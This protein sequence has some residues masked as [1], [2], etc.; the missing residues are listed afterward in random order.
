M[1]ARRPATLSREAW[2]QSTF[3]QRVQAMLLALEMALEEATRFEL[4]TDVLAGER[5]AA[6]AAMREWAEEVE[7]RDGLHGAPRP[8]R[9]GCGCLGWLLKPLQWIGVAEAG[10]EYRVRGNVT[11][12]AAAAIRDAAVRHSAHHIRLW[13][14]NDILWDSWHTGDDWLYW[15]T[16]GAFEALARRLQPVVPVPH[17]VEWAPEEAWKGES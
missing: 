1:N 3:E 2:E 13:R 9:W 10:I 6:E 11:P 16:P 14:G 12:R 4:L 17:P 5:Q 7:R 15:V 8:L